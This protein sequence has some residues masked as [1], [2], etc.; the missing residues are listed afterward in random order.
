MQA[1]S[2][3]YLS[4]AQAAARWGVHP[5]TIKRLIRTG[6]LPAYRLQRILRIDVNDLDACFRPTVDEVR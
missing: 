2:P 4:T 5:E 6:D 3:T 1:T